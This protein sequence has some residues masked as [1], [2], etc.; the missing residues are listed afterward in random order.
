MRST[1]RA[2]GRG[3]AGG[4]GAGRAVAVVAALA[5]L[6]GAVAGCTVRPVEGDGKGGPPVR[7][8]LPGGTPSASRPSGGGGDGGGGT[9]PGG[10]R[11]ATV[12]ARVLWSRGST[13]RDVREL[14]ARLRQI[15]W[16]FEGPTGT[17]DGPTEKAVRGFQGKRGLPRTGRTDT[18][19]WQ[20]LKGMTREPGRW[21]LYQMGGQ[22]ADAPDPR[23]R[24]GRVLCI[25]KESRT[26]RWMADGRTLQT[27]PVR[28]G[29]QY[30][31]TR[32][33]VFSVYWKSRDHWSTLYDSPMPYAMFFSGGQA[34]HFSA[35]FAARGYAGASHGCVNV[36]DEAAI[37]RIFAQVR[38]GDKVVIHW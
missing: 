37:A 15:A 28:F 10:S 34:V 36:R 31:P 8:E 29:S 3:R 21:D 27:L 16:L 18:V 5:A 20:R 38:N 35:D 14:Q 26:L 23:C 4:A 1:G 33:G 9:A 2:A 19:T 32:E 6:A 17:Y 13:G 11:D 12:P 24:T 30:T 22:P 7:V 25:S